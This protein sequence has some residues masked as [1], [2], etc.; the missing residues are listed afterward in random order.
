VYLVGSSTHCNMMHGAYNVKKCKLTCNTS[1]NWP[2][3]E[4][5]FDPQVIWYLKFMLKP[6]FE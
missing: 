2:M 4:E 5:N 6:I 3:E 1:Y